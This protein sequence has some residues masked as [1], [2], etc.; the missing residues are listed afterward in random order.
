MRLPPSPGEITGGEM[1]FDDRDLM[2][3]SEEGMR[4][5]RGARISR[6]FQDP[7]T[8]LDSLQR[9]SDHLVETIRT[10]EPRISRVGTTTE[11]VGLAVRNGRPGAAEVAADF[12]IVT[13]VER[14]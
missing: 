10:H 3:L 2:D 4:D 6:V 7:M 12:E 14:K 9:V 13:L 1:T 11:T 5:L 8:C